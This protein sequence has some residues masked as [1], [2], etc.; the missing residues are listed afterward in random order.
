MIL[1]PVAGSPERHIIIGP[2]SLASDVRSEAVLGPLPGHVYMALDMSVGRYT[3]RDARTGTRIHDPRMEKLGL[4]EKVVGLSSTH[5]RPK[6]IKLSP[7]ELR[8]HG[9]DVQQF[10]LQ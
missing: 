2:A 4:K 9:I 8:L 5:I 1:R 6:D 3:F 10:L 7:E